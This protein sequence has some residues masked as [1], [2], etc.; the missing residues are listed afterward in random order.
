MRSKS[1]LK[2]KM[3]GQLQWVPWVAQQMDDSE[4]WFWELSW[5]FFAWCELSLT[6]HRHQADRSG[7]LG[8]EEFLELWRS[9]N[10]WKV[11]IVCNFKFMVILIL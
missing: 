2:V 4:I 10:T 9:I 7:K 6:L 5:L 1:G 3:K 8:F 11:S